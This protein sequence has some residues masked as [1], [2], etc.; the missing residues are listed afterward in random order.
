MKKFFL[1]LSI[2]TVFFVVYHFFIFGNFGNGYYM[3]N[4]SRTILE[5]KKVKNFFISHI[6]N[7]KQ[8]DK[9]LIAL[10]MPETFYT[11]KNG[12]SVICD[13]IVTY[14]IVDTKNNKLYETKN[15]D[16]FL[17]K[18]KY[19]KI[20]VKFDKEE[21]DV[22]KAYIARHRHICRKHAHIEECKED[23]KYPIQRY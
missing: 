1:L 3:T 6:L 21:I 15:Y 4:T 22:A 12:S 14:V 13:P 5:N 18:L 23:F 19:F 10:R 7:I 20:D 17:S 9:Y 8:S 11:C 16:Q 2:L